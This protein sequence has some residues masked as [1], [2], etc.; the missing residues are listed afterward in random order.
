[1]QVEAF[2]KNFWPGPLYHDADKTFYKAL[3]GGKVVKGNLLAFAN[4]FSAAWKNARR[5]T[6]S[7]K[8]SNLVGDGLTMGGLFIVG[9]DGG[10]VF[11]HVEETFGQHASCEQVRARTAA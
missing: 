9:T 8:D 11:K 3:G 1:M 10:V 5:A 7:V 4:P 2:H 6:K